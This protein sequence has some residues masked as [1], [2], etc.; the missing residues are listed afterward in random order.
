MELKK[1]VVYEEKKNFSVS[2]IQ[3]MN[4]YFSGMRN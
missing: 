1:R 2:S 4:S 3:K